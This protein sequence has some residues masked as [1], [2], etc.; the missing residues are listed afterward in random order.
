MSERKQRVVACEVCG[1][2]VAIKSRV[3]LLHGKTLRYC[4]TC[5]TQR[6]FVKVEKEDA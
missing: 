4:P 3:L 1:T 6:R 5:D 2:E